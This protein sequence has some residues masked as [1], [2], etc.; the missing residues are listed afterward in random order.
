[1]LCPSSLRDRHDRELLFVIG[2]ETQTGAL[3]QMTEKVRQ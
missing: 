2:N 1:V 3:E